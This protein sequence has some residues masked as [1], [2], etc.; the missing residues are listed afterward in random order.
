MASKRFAIKMLHPEFARQPEVISRFQREAEAAAAIQSPFV[1]GVY[2]VDRTADGRPFMVGEFLEGKELG[3]HLAS[4]GRMQ[5]P[6]AVRIVRQITQAL[7]AAHERGVVHR[8]MKPENVFLTGDVSRPTAK[9][10]DFGIS[11]I[12]DAPGTALTKTGMIMGTPSYMA[13][14]QA[15]GE[16][17]DHRA[18]I[19]A[20][21]AILY[22]GVTGKRPFDRGDPTATLMAVLTEDPARPR[23]IEPSIPE[24]LE[25]V[26]QRAMAKSPS[27]RYQTMA[28]LD[29]DLIPFDAERDL[30]PATASVGSAASSL[31]RQT[32]EIA[33]ARPLIVLM[34]VLGAFW[35]FGSVVTTIT[36]GVRMARGGGPTANLTSSE[37][38]LLVLGLVFAMITPVVLVARY[39]SRTVWANS[40]RALD[41]ADKLRRPVVVGLGAYGF[42]SLLVRVIEAIVL[43]RAVGVA[44]PVWD[45]LLCIIGLVAALGAIYVV[46][47]ERKR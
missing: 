11:K 24:A 23:S 4:V 45:V 42:G 35:L 17:V 16:H 2:D 21:G 26:I 41:V 43:R 25:M 1:V 9:V 3:D 38:V 22:A 5:V 18:D 30:A 33:L 28:E 44:W 40:V 14:E 31:N 8:D 13:P 46:D 47:A 20:V 34:T 6:I 12:G 15:R 19:Y 29:A 10:I 39:L 37:A 36:A 7:G 32:R 27:D